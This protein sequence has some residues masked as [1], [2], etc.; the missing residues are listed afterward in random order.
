MA[1]NEYV[2]VLEKY[3]KG[4]EI[5]ISFKE[6]I[7]KTELAVLVNNTRENELANN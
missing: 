5:I 1:V 3:Y 7:I 2:D 6:Q 4:K